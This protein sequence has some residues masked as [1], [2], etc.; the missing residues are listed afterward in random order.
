MLQFLTIFL[1]QSTKSQR[2][3]GLAAGVQLRS[4]QQ[5]NDDFIESLG[6]EQGQSI[7]GCSYA[8]TMLLLV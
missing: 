3:C 5:E 4:N 6:F 8:S 2:L 7:E 1:N